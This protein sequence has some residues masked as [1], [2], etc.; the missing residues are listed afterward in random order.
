M[1]GT[2]YKCELFIGGKLVEPAAGSYYERENPATGEVVSVVAEGGGEEV[3]RAVEAAREAFPTWSAT[4]PAERAR[5]VARIADAVEAERERLA[6][7]NTRETGKP[8]RESYGVELRGVIRTFRY[9]GGLLPQLSGRTIETSEA[10]VSITRREPVGVVAQIVPWNFPLLLASWKVA[11]ALLAGCTVVVKPSELT[12]SATVELARMA[13]AV[14]VPPGV[15]N[16]VPGRGEVAGRAL[17][18]HPGVAKVAFTGSTEVGRE[19]MARAARD[20]KRVSLELGGKAPNIVF[21]DVDIEDCIEANLR[22]GFFNQGENCTAVTRLLVHRRI[23]EPFVERFVDRVRAIRL[24]DPMDEKTEMGAL[25]SREH[26]ER[27]ARYCEGAVRE[28]GVLLTGGA[29]PADEGLRR[30]YFFMPTVIDNVEP[31]H[32]IAC[33]EVFGPVVAVMPFDGEEEAVEIANS[34]VYGL[35][36]GVWSRDIKRALRVAAAVR[37]GYIWVNTYG[38]I[39]PETPYGGFKQS[40]IGKELGEEGLDNYLETK[41]VNIYLGERVPRWYGL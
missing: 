38:G 12:P 18:D 37:A 6:V 9:Y 20:I 1:D 4:P 33:E 32:T 7:L 29:R 23:Y 26:L 28:G 13:T 2:P 15:I 36:G 27:V 41:T 3:A 34:T 22:G 19:I 24:G 25:I 40:G 11:P 17:V 35:A 8:Y 10:M 21:D 16:V 39:L 5:L 31:S 30:G 14:G